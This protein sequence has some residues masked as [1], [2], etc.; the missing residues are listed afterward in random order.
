MFL[1][2]SHEDAHGAITHLSVFAA[3][4][5]DARARDALDAL[6][7]KEIR[8]SRTAAHPVQLTLIGMGTAAELGD[9][10]APLFG[11][12][13]R[14]TS[15]T[16][17]VPTRH[18]KRRRTGA[19]KLDDDG[20]WIGSPEHDLLRL[21]RLLGKPL[22]ARVEPTD[23]VRLGDRLVR[24]LEFHRWRQ[25]GSG[26]RGDERGYG[27][28]IEFRE[29]LRGPLALGFGAHFG[30]GVFAPDVAVAES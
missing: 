14:W 13:R 19:P 18:A 29:P 26:R 23:G 6:A 21:L 7:A 11:E 16:P 30:L 15:L 28:S 10:G 25:R 9:A 8:T 1:P 2:E 24:W 4:G 17:F 20:H 12:S 22:V 5:F 27:F 3:G